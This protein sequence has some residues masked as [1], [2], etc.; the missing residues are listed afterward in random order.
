MIPVTRLGAV[1]GAVVAVWLLSDAQK[2][3]AAD[4]TCPKTAYPHHHDTDDTYVAIRPPEAN[5]TVEN[6]LLRDG[7]P[8]GCENPRFRLVYS[9]DVDPDPNPDVA[10]HKL[11]ERLTQNGNGWVDRPVNGDPGYGG[12]NFLTHDDKNP[13]S[14]RPETGIRERHSDHLVV[15]WRGAVGCRRPLVWIFQW[16][17]E[18]G[19]EPGHPQKVHVKPVLLEFV[20]RRNE[21]GCKEPGNRDA[22][23]GGP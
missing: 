3:A 16:P 18:S 19:E 10:A 20:K 17:D 1:L 11:F 5:E 7:K 12:P 14:G 2:P 15:G 13:T 21:D 4:E 8:V 22:D 6:V 23:G 9:D